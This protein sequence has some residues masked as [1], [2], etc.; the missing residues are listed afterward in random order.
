MDAVSGENYV[1][2]VRDQGDCGSCYSF[3]STG[4][5]GDVLAIHVH[6]QVFFAFISRLLCESIGW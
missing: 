1:T 2:P 4:A 5:R 6:G 3:G